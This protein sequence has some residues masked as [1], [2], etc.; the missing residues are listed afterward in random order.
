MARQI[1]RRSSTGRWVVGILLVALVVAIGVIVFV[2]GPG[3]QGAGADKPPQ[4]SEPVNDVNSSEVAE[5]QFKEFVPKSPSGVEIESEPKL[6]ELPSAAPEQASSQAENLIEQAMQSL[7]GTTPDVVKARDLLNETLFL[8]L[9]GQQR[10]TVKQKMSELSDK[11]LFSKTV[12]S[13]DSLCENYT[14]R[15]GDTLVQIGD[16]HK[17]PSQILMRINNIVDSRGLRAG[18]SIKVINGPFHCRISRSQFTLD[19]YLQKTYVKTFPVGLGKPGH[20]T[21]TGLWVVEPGGKLVKPTWTDPSTGR[22]YRASDLDYPLGSRWIGLV[23]VS[24]NAENR[25]GFAIHGTK[26]PNEIGAAVSRGCIRMYNGD[27][28]LVYKLLEPGHSQVRV[29]E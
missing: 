26:D 20:Q 18:E 22:T 14:V 15:P 5:V 8:P 19:L 7:E 29:I 4:E 12:Y 28:I 23:G 11:W 13:G 2:M 27:A 9:T 3:Q 16:E 17:V 1:Y 6:P 25:T 24:G 21:P 10:E